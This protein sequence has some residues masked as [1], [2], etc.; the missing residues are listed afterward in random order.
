M[1]SPYPAYSPRMPSSNVHY[2]NI[3]TNA[4]YPYPPHSRYD[5]SAASL[6]SDSSTEHEGDPVK[7]AQKEYGYGDRQARPGV[8]VD[9]RAINRTPSPTPSEAEELSK[10]ILDWDRLL[11]WRYWVRREWLWYYVIFVVALTGGILFTVYHK[12]IVNWLKPAA[13]WMHDLPY[14][15][16]IPIGVFF[17]ISFP[18]LFGHEI[19]AILC[20]LVWDLGPGFA[21]VAAGTFIGEL[22]NFYAFKYCCAAR[23]EK[24]EKT[25]LQYACLARVVRD[26]GFKIALIARLSAIPG[27]FTTA[28]F[29]TCGMGVITFS[30]AAILSLPKQFITVYL[31][32]ALEQSEDGTSST[33]D[34]IIRDA[35]LGLTTLMTFGAMW[36]IYHKMNQAKPL[37]IYDRRK[38]RQA[39]LMEM[40][41]A[42][43]SLPYGSGNSV[44]L[45]STTSVSFNPAASSADI[46]LTK[47]GQPQSQYQTQPGVYA[48]RPQRPGEQ[49]PMSQYSNDSHA[50][51]PGAGYPYPTPASQLPSRPVASPPRD[52]FSDAARVPNYSSPRPQPPSQPQPQ[53]ISYQRQAPPRGYGSPP[54]DMLD[55]RGG[56]SRPPHTYT[57]STPAAQRLSSP[58]PPAARPPSPSAPQSP[59]PRNYPAPTGPPPLPSMSGQPPRTSG[60]G[61]NP[62]ADPSPMP[63]PYEQGRQG[64]G[65]VEEPSD[66]T[67]YTA[68][69]GHSRGGTEF[70][71]AYEATSM[72]ST[73]GS[74]P[75]AYDEHRNA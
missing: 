9:V 40:S 45:E 37:V 16:L 54:P 34:T 29:S 28:V 44:M 74:A 64:G 66:A 5:A 36:Y 8:A 46:P 63:N 70:D 48:P 58:P 18:P 67:F 72:A 38:A 71:A 55:K 32:V 60:D 73:E 52:P 39:K 49:Y 62:F 22:G 53:G 2:S 30:I 25:K 3:N 59:T 24:L 57:Q 6:D 19:V 11:K 33:K 43:P 42:A 14:G 7:P 50:L 65:H 75:P 10:G 21:I 12:K 47:Y 27:H 1:T 68:A 4:S 31:G 15:W 35:V 41:G 69:G 26:G 20:G 61:T 17:V 23:G 56:G 13:D 51:P